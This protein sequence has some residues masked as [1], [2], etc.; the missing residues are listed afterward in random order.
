MLTK[1]ILDGEDGK[2]VLFAWDPTL[3][4]PLYSSQYGAYVQ[5]DA[6][7]KKIIPE[8]TPGYFVGKPGG[9][10]VP[11]PLPDY[12]SPPTPVDVAIPGAQFVITSAKEYIP[13]QNHPDYPGAFGTMLIVNSNAPP[14][15]YRVFD[16]NTNTLTTNYVT[17]PSMLGPGLTLEKDAN[18]YLVRY[19]SDPKSPSGYSEYKV[20]AADIAISGD[21]RN[22]AM[23]ILLSRP[24]NVNADTNYAADFLNALEK[25][26]YNILPE[27]KAMTFHDAIVGFQSILALDKNLFGNLHSTS[28][29][30]LNTIEDQRQQISGVS[31]N[32]E[33]IDMMRYSNHYN[34]AVRFMT[35][36]DE[37]LDTVINR[38]GLVGR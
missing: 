23:N 31:E 17:D 21:W 36:M 10:A 11:D 14:P 38:M 19:S 2:P 24:G 27:E 7:G 28:D 26:T 16:T 33:A 15:Y 12:T 5:V 25:L 9:P 22:N 32:E 37:A 20:T 13:D 30:I 1:Y 3:E 34:A 29:R 8:R 18:G 6:D 35:A 4:F